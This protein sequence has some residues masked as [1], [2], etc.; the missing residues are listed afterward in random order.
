MSDIMWLFMWYVYTQSVNMNYI[1]SVS[2]QW[3]SNKQGYFY[4]QWGLLISVRIVSYNM[5]ERH[6]RW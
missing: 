2:I 6:A 4:Y 1:V 5:I 3:K